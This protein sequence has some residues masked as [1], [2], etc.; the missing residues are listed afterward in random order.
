MSM[1]RSSFTSP[2]PH[3]VEKINGEAAAVGLTAGLR[4]EF[5]FLQQASLSIS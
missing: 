4:I 2:L 1:E 5:T 3:L